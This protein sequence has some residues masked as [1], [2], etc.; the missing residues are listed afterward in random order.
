MEDC[1]ALSFSRS[2]PAPN[3]GSDGSKL[4]NVPRNCSRS[5][6]KGLQSRGLPLDFIAHLVAKLELFADFAVQ[7]V[8]LG[9]FFRDSA[10]YLRSLR[11]LFIDLLGH[12]TQF[13][14]GLNP[15][16]LKAVKLALGS[17]R[18]MLRLVPHALKGLYL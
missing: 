6:P 3:L 13:G 9:H 8:K 7:A 15:L 14:A 16:P 12:G 4:L 5:A 11:P 18:T 10:V 1:A 2:F 17:N